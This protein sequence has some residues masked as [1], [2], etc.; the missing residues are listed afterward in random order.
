MKKIL[1]IAIINIV[2]LISFIVA[3][4]FDK[5]VKTYIILAILL[6]TFAA[7]Q[8]VSIWLINNILDGKGD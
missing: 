4:F 1:C 5:P 7:F 6:M 3:C 2:G 8:I